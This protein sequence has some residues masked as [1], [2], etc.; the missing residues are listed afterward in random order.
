[1]I[2]PAFRGAAQW[3]ITVE[4][5]DHYMYFD[6]AREAPFTRDLAES[7]KA[8]YLDSVVSVSAVDRDRDQMTILDGCEAVLEEQSTRAL[9]RDL[10]PYEE[11]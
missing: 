3:R 9:Q 11:A 4:N 7:E 1:M 10:T 2:S 5:G 8:R 6:P